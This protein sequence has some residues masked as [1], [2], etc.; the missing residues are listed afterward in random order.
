MSEK[1]RATC[2]RCTHWGND[3][4]M[5][6]ELTVKCNH[7][8][9]YKGKSSVSGSHQWEAVRCAEKNG[10]G[11]CADYKATLFWRVVALIKKEAKQ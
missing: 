4:L 7:P 9:Y 8:K 2:S 10:D 1:R 6:D 3:L 11:R 5:Y